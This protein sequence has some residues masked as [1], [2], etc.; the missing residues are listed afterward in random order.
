MVV[1]RVV[2]VSMRVTILMMVSVPVM[3]VMAVPMIMMPLILL[4]VVWA[5]PDKSG[6][7]QRRASRRR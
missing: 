6:F 2:T 5:L 1:M 3:V 7:A 4:V